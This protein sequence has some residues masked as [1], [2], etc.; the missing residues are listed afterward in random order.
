MKSNA[1]FTL[2]S[3]VENLTLVGIAAIDATGNSGANKIVG[4][5]GANVITG[6]L[7][8]DL[9][10]GNGGSDTFDFNSIK[11]LGLGTK[12]AS[13]R[14]SLTELI[15]SIFKTSMRTSILVA[16]T[17]SPFLQVTERSSLVQAAR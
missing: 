7:G 14:I 2:S 8:K 17:C 11:D 9:M 3:N 12:S 6:G 10:S 4:N 13:F 5:N 16:T 15:T 1:T